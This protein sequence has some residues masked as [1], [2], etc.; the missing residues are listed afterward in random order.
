MIPEL[1]EWVRQNC[2]RPNS[3]RHRDAYPCKF[4]FARIPRSLSEGGSATISR[5]SMRSPVEDGNL[6]RAY[7][8]GF[9][10]MVSSILTLQVSAKFSAP[11]C[12]SLS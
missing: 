2:P 7:F 10:S 4:S 11:P 3:R 6:D 12:N 8:R 9:T 1:D 5:G